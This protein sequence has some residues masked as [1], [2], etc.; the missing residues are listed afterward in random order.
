MRCIADAARGGREHWRCALGAMVTLALLATGPAAEC[1]QSGRSGWPRR[2][3][4][5]NDR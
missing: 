5:T 3:L 4:V 2:V 1:Q